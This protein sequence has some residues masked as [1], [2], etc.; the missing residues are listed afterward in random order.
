MP[1]AWPYGAGGPNFVKTMLRLATSH[2]SVSVVTDQLGQPTWTG[3]LDREIV[4][5]PDADTA[6]GVCYA[7][8]SGEASKYDFT[9]E[10]FRVAGFDPDRVKP[11]T[12]A[13]F[14]SPAP[15][16]GYS[17]LGHDAWGRAGI[18][19]MRNWRA[20][21]SAAYSAGALEIVS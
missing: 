10:I 5:L 8:N 15:R 6:P 9:R 3:N 11:T 4:G 14:I 2:D 12:S 13:K 16:P 20:T 1:T 17:V 21:L 19:P 7:T 18:S